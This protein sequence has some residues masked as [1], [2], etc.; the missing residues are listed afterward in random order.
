MVLLAIGVFSI[1]M[2][3]L[4]PVFPSVTLARVLHDAG[5]RH[6]VAAS[7]GYGV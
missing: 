3:W 4:R 1:I 7:A 5:C 2:P 6:P